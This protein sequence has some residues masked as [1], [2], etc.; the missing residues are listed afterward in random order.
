[1]VPS[2]LLLEHLRHVCS[3]TPWKT[4]EDFTDKK[5]LD[6][7]REKGN[8]DEASDHDE[9]T[10]NS[11]AI[12]ESFCQITS[13]HKTDD[14]TNVGTIAETRLPGGSDGVLSITNWYTVFALEGS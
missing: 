11:L 2:I 6:S 12:T 4:A 5:N 9:S 3:L 14:F 7:G 13:E 1:M 10:A 8:E